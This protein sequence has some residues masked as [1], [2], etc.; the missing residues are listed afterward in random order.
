MTQL[1]RIEAPNLANLTPKEQRRIGKLAG[2]IYNAMSRYP[3]LIEELTVFGQFVFT[4]SKLEN[5]PD[6]IK[7]KLMYA[8]FDLEGKLHELDDVDDA[9]APS[10]EDE[11]RELKRKLNED[12]DN[13]D[14]DDDVTTE[15]VPA[16]EPGAGDVIDGKVVGEPESR[17]KAAPP[18]RGN[19]GNG[20]KGRN[21]KKAEAE[22]SSKA[23]GA[24]ANG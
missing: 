2:L 4:R 24:D 15:S 23:E 20:G 21:A 14:D 7:I 13:D 1:A 11:L 6:K 22:K 19:G 16:A 17:K 9:P 5:V 8:A 12:D 10:D 18:R 3:W